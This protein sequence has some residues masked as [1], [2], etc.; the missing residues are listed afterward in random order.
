MEKITLLQRPVANF[1][2][3]PL[4]FWCLCPGLFCSFL[5]NLVVLVL[6]LEVKIQT[7]SLPELAMGPDW[8]ISKFVCPKAK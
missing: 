8:F 1:Q 4:P 7:L 6:N 2:N 5:L 3:N